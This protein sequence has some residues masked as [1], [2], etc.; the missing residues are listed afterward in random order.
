M[1]HFTKM[2]RKISEKT[3]EFPVF[4]G[5]IKELPSSRFLKICKN[6]EA[7]LFFRPIQ[8]SPLI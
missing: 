1:N 7:I 8:F 4:F 6:E 3:K 5:L 2:P